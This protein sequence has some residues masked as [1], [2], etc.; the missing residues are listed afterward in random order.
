M[1]L[2]ESAARLPGWTLIRN[3]D[4]KSVRYRTPKGIEVGQWAYKS[5]FKHYQ[6]TGIAPDE[7]L[8]ERWKKYQKNDGPYSSNKSGSSIL[9]AE[10]PVADSDETLT[11][12]LP[13]P[14]PAPASRTKSG[15]FTSREL[16][17]GFATILVILTSMIAMSLTLPAAQMTDAEVKAIAIPLANIVERS[18][19]NKTIGTMVVGKSDYLTLGYALFTYINRVTDAAREMRDAK[20]S[21]NAQQAQGYSPAGTNGHGTGAA[22]PTVA[23]RT[24]P[25]GLR[26]F[27][28]NG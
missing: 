6:K 3:P 7:P 23:L 11:I 22:G 12:E 4:T 9:S 26:G 18:K 14:K 8:G 2:M 16:S 24:A 5:A 1:P 13:E 27:T 10:L 17:D 20:R 19:Y 28:G 25:S 15:L 21:G